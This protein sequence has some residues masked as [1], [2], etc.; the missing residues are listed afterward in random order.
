MSTLEDGKA[1]DIVEIDLAGKTSFADRMIIASA[2]SQRQVAALADRLVRVLR[3]AGHPTY[4]IEGLAQG[5][6]APATAV[7]S[8]E[9]FPPYRSKQYEVGAKADFGRFGAGVALFQTTQPSGTTDPDTLVFGV[10]GEQRNRGLEVTLFGEPQPGVRLLGGVTLLNAELTETAGGTN[11]GNNAP[12]VSDYQVNLGAEWDLP[13]L[14]GVTLSGRVLHTGPQFL[15]AANTQEVDS[16]TR[17]DIGARYVTE[18]YGTPVTFNA[19]VENVTD[20]SYWASASG[21]YLTQGDPLTGK[22]SVSARF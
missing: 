8:G 13:Y 6:E 20:E 4:G 10:D 22:L 3:E 2:G 12:G 1:E 14:A 7:N 17:L 16:W 18:M 11:D 9:I 5:P 21:G 19:F 15:D